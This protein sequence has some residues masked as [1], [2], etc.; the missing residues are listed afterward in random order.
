MVHGF[1]SFQAWP[2][3]SSLEA[4]LRGARGYRQQGPSFA[5][6][7]AEVICPAAVGGRKTEMKI[8]EIENI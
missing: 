5:A 7:A 1:L 4:H 6:A 8:E 3:G 2:L